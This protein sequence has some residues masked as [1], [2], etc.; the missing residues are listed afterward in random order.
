MLNCK[1]AILSLLKRTKAIEDIN[2]LQAFTGELAPVT[3]S[4][5]YNDLNNLPNIPDAQIQSDWNQSDTDAKDYIKNKPTIPTVP[6]NLVQSASVQN[7]VVCTQAQYDALVS[8]NT[9]DAN[10][11]Y[12]IIESV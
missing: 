2:E 11:E 10:T 8:N 3:F 12:N 6:Q 1:K 4:N 5:D 7:I 9:V